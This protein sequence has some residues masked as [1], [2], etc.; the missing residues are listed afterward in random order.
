[1]GYMKVQVKAV[2]KPSILCK[3]GAPKKHIGSK[4]G[5]KLPIPTLQGKACLCFRY[6]HRCPTMPFMVFIATSSHVNVYVHALGP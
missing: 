4:G 3:P 1:M 2:V 5:A 6:V